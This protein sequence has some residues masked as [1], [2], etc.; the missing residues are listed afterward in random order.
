MAQRVLTGATEASALTVW[1]HRTFGHGTLDLAERP[2]EL[3]DAYDCLDFSDTTEQDLDA[4]V[5][6]E[7]RRIVTSPD[8]TPTELPQPDVSPTSRD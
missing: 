1:A 3:D 7:A 2:V 4:D 8:V 6:A 5:I